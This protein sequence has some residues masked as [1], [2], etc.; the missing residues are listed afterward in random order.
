MLAIKQ[1]NQ[2][3]SGQ[4]SHVPPRRREATLKNQKRMSLPRLKRLR[5]LPSRVPVRRA[6]DVL[7]PQEVVT[8]RAK[9]SKSLQS[10][11]KRKKG[12]PL[13]AAERAR[14]QL[15][16]ELRKSRSMRASLCSPKPPTPTRTRSKSVAVTGTA[17][18][19]RMPRLRSQLTKRRMLSSRK[20]VLLDKL[21]RQRLQ[22]RAKIIMSSSMASQSHGLKRRTTS[23]IK[24]R[25]PDVR[26][27]SNNNINSN[28]SLREGEV[29]LMVAMAD[30]PH[31]STRQD[32]NTLLCELLS[33]Q[34]KATS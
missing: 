7:D 31:S 19:V 18:T 1:Q 2:R 15:K 30:V 20:I 16:R 26:L 12:R 33:T 6:I 21:Q 34:V 3:V 17:K 24:A 22:M 23:S 5:R 28:S 27:L 10:L 32:L 4:E 29:V 9:L 8:S 14:S 25:H 13:V 11:S